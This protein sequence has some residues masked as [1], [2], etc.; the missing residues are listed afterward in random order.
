MSS[1]SSFR[2]RL[3][4]LPLRYSAPAG[5]YAPM[6]SPDDAPGIGD[7][8]QENGPRVKV[9][10]DGYGVVVTTGGA[11]APSGPSAATPS[12]GS[13]TILPATPPASESAS[14]PEVPASPIFG[15]VQAPAPAGY[16]VVQPR[17]KSPEPS[18]SGSPDVL[19][20]PIFGA[21][22]SAASAAS[23]LSPVEPT[24]P[25]SAASPAPDAT[26]AAAPVQSAPPVHGKPSAPAES[27]PQEPDRPEPQQPLHPARPPAPTAIAWESVASAASHAAAIPL[28][29]QVAEE[30][31]DD[32]EAP[33]GAAELLQLSEEPEPEAGARALPDGV[34]EDG[35]YADVDVAIVMESTYPYLKGGVSAVVHDIITGNPDLTF[36]IIHITWDSHSPLK[37]LYGMPDNV[38]W[39]RVLYLSMEEHQEDFLRARPRDLRMNRRQRRELSR[40]ILGAMLSLAQDGQTEPLWDIISEG[41]SASRRYPVWA[42]LGTREFMEAYHDMMPDL[43]MSMTDVFWCLRDFFSLAYAVLAEPV[44]RAQVYH[45]HTTGYAML[46]GVNAAREHGTK[47]LLTEH[48]LY[49]RD[50]VNTLLERRLDLN[51]RLTDYRT[52]DVTGRERMWMAWWLEMGRLCY[53]YAYASTYLYPRAITEAN[54]LG[55][56]AGRAIVI[57]NGIVTSEFDASYV[58]RLAAIEEIKKEGADK[59]LWKLVYIA[60]VVPIKGLLDMIDSVR[61]MV[62]RGL[63]IHL[64]VCGPTEHMPS[65]FEQCLTRIVEQGLESVIT[66]RGTVKVRELLPEFDLF[67]LPS[68]NEGLPVVS[69]ETMGA[70]IPTVSTDVGAVRSVVEDMI[71]TDDGQTWD[72]CGIIIEPGDP[73]VMA[74]KVQEVISDVDLYE[75]LS[76][77]ARGR[78]EAAYDLVK[79][80]ASYNKIYRQGGAGEQAG[81]RADRGGA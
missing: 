47:V 39:V 63:N 35:V 48:N 41:L 50:T 27:I 79:V 20:S 55:G 78:V 17:P 60:R 12:A 37:D 46:L 3:E 65:Y 11:S 34:P 61:L 4:S 73:T 6:P 2:A 76:L 44:P 53:P 40:R 77:N 21:V 32:E 49:V 59:H 45:A 18:S 26:G 81:A 23:A 72:P 8:G 58:A 71:V 62:D 10:P 75:R 68:Y 64:D 70:G 1:S 38:A 57:P 67:V 22:S 56:D 13:S 31:T 9:G 25:R 30:E 54:E 15:V 66:I 19:D 51:I 14:T 29:Q 43:G 69:L 7:R 36:G 42:I 80:N 33:A 5:G 52:F 74:D 28:S 24:A 16:G